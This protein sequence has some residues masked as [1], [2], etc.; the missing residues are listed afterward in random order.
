MTDALIF[1]HVRTPRGRGRP[2]GSLH[3][4]T[5]IELAAQ[6]LRALRDRNGLD[7]SVVDDVVLGCVTR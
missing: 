4:I 3:R 2:D 5:P 6:S 7:T 1:D